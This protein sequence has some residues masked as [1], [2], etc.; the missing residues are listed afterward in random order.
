ML[1][2]DLDI[3]MSVLHS[4]GHEQGFIST[5]AVHAALSEKGIEFKHRKTVQRRLERFEAQGLV[6]VDRRGRSLCWRARPGAS[7][8]A[9]RAGAMMTFD[10]ALA[11]QALQR[12]SSRQI[13]ALVSQHLSA[14]F[15]V[16][17]DRLARINS[18]SERHY[19]KWDGKVAVE[20]GGF[21]LRHPPIDAE[22]RNR[23]RW[24]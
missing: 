10:E 1:L 12:F 16:A 21:A 11:L 17:R 23:D 7:G 15:D 19:S 8:M 18:L 24:T 6:E 2:H 22:T 14:M 20:G 5:A 13:P 9:A 4:A 3:M